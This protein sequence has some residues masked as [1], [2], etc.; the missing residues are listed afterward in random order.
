MD[1]SLKQEIERL[2]TR[3]AQLEREI[4]RL[5][6]TLSDKNWQVDY[7]RDQIPLPTWR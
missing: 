7:L 4:T 2:R 6:S 3:N 1:D 5:K